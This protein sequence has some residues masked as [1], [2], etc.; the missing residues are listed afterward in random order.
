MNSPGSAR[1]PTWRRAVLHVL[2][3]LF[4]WAVF[5]WFWVIVM[6]QAGSR[7][8]LWLLLVVSVLL[9]PVLTVAWV[10][11]NLALYQRKGPRRNVPQVDVSYEVDFYGRRIEADW[12]RLAGQPRINIQIEGQVKRY[13]PAAAG[14]SD[15]GQPRGGGRATFRESWR[16]APVSI[17]PECLKRS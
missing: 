7:A 2:I 3:V 6:G 17:E 4:G 12:K 5:V 14:E 1:L 11:H 16:L 10:L 13:V 15:H 9:F 8:D